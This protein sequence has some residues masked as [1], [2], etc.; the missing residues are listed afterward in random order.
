M[1]QQLVNSPMHDHEESILHRRQA[2]QDRLRPT[3]SYSELVRHSKPAPVQR[4]SIVVPVRGPPPPADANEIGDVA[5]DKWARIGRSR[6]LFVE[7]TTEFIPYL[8]AAGSVT[9]SLATPLRRPNTPQRV[10]PT[11]HAIFT[12]RDPQGFVIPPPV[13]HLE[14]IQ[15]ARGRTPARR[16]A[17]PPL[18][19][20]LN[21]AA[22]VSLNLFPETGPQTPNFPVGD[23]WSS[24]NRFRAEGLLRQRRAAKILNARAGKRKNRSAKRP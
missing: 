20:P 9:H 6:L 10:P 21:T 8:A 1:G 23:E 7:H 4:S 3:K 24:W 14:M 2:I 17:L 16:R 18:R 11:S 13:E 22:A 5:D 12:Q 15:M 19:Q